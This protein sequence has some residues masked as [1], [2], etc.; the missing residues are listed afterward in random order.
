MSIK[1]C[2][3]YH[4]IFRNTDTERGKIPDS[5]DSSVHHHIRDTL[6]NLDRNSQHTDLYV[7][8]FHLLQKVVRMIN[9]N[10][11]QVSTDQRRAQYRKQ[12][13]SSSPKCFR[14]ESC[15]SAPPRL[16]TPK[17]KALCISVNPRKCSKTLMSASTSYPTR[18]RPGDIHIRQ[19]FCYL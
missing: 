19:V 6:G 10:S 9:R 3:L 17:R 15:K 14:P 1:G 4:D 13:Q 18:V 16:P 12:P 7:I 2:I 5:L 11:V 8:F